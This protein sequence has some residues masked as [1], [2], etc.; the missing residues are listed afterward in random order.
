MEKKPSNIH[1]LTSLLG[2]SMLEIS[3]IVMLE[4]WCD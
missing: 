4:F 3:E 2:L 1:Q